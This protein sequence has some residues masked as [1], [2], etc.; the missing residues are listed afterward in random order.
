V[1]YNAAMQ[2]QLPFEESPDTAA[3]AAQV[4]MNRI[5]STQEPISQRAVIGS[6]VPSEWPP[7]PAEVEVVTPVNDMPQVGLDAVTA[8]HNMITPLMPAG[9]PNF[10]TVAG[11]ALKSMHVD[12]LNRHKGSRG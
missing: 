7:K 12:Q 4:E 10:D 6:R 11:N 5:T 2:E 8:A 1:L 9:N 3:S